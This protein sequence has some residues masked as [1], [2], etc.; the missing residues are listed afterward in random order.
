MKKLNVCFDARKI[1]KQNKKRFNVLRNILRNW[2]GINKIAMQL[3][4]TRQL[5][6]GIQDTVDEKGS[7][8]RDKVRITIKDEK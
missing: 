6:F 7:R 5:L 3:H 2:L 4:D 8:L 1:K